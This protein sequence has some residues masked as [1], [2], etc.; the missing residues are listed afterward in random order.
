VKHNIFPV[1]KLSHNPALGD[2]RRRPSGRRGGAG[3]ALVAT[4]S[5]QLGTYTLANEL[6]DLGA[7]PGHAIRRKVLTLVDTLRNFA[8]FFHRGGAE[9]CPGLLSWFGHQSHLR[10]CCIYYASWRTLVRDR[11][12]RVAEDRFELSIRGALNGHQRQSIK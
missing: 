5:K 2:F 1:Q 7:V 3:L 8:I 12:S 9:R 10:C 4:L 6:I 11:I